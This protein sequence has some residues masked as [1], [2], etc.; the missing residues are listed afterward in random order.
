[1]APIQERDA[2]FVATNLPDVD[3]AW[4]QLMRAC[5]QLCDAI[6]ASG[7][8]KEMDEVFQDVVERAIGIFRREEDV[9]AASMAPHASTHRQGH[10]AVLSTL[11]KL[12]Q[13]Y[14]DGGGSPELAVRTR[15]ELLDFLREHHAL[16]DG[17]LGRHVREWL[18]TRDE[19]D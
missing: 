14:R 15:G 8:D 9:L 6:A 11:A 4:P 18:K 2:T 12:R 7:R 1:M 19:D 17:L 16:L 13:E 5:V 3:E 10:L